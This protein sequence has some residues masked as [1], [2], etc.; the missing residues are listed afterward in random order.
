MAEKIAYIF[1]GLLVLLALG[2]CFLIN[3]YFGIFFTFFTILVIYFVMGVYKSKVD[4]ALE[5]VAK[6]LG[7]SCRKHPLKH[8]IVEGIHNGYKT[9]IGVYSDLDGFG[10]LGTYL[11]ATTGMGG[12]LASLNVRN[13]TGIKIY[14]K[15]DVREE[16]V[17]S[18]NYPVILKKDIILLVLPHV[19]SDVKE[20]VDQYRKLEKELKKVS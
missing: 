9:E 14:H 5:G 3:V 7:L 6:E 20:I 12:G 13:F 10:G 16:K 19:S 4:K 2:F 18:D 1:L 17:L 15:L 8:A 11:V